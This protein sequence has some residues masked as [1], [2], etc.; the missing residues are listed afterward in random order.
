MRRFF[1][2][3]F[4]VGRECRRS[5]FY[6]I[7]VF[8]FFFFLYEF[9]YRKRERVRERERER[10]RERKK[11]IRYIY[12]NIYDTDVIGNTSAGRSEIAT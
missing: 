7:C 5:V 8:F 11:Y 6:S 10:E 3:C 9:E 12:I 2:V 4:P 1:L